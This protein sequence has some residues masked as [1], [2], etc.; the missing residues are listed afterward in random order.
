LKRRLLWQKKNKLQDER[1]TV[2]D[3]KN[4]LYWGIVIGSMT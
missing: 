2:T 4:Q 3:T 1:S